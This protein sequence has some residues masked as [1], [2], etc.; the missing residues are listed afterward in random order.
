[1]SFSRRESGTGMLNILIDKLL[2]A[3]SDAIERK[4]KMTP[5]L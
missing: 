4:V 3:R 1:M 2:T 5:Y